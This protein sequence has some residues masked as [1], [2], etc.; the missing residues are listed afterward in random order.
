VK[1]RL[2]TVCLV[3]AGLLAGCAGAPRAQPT[4][5][6]SAS[7]PSGTDCLQSSRV[8]SF[9]RLD[10]RNLI[11]YA[12]DRQNAYHV[13][14]AMACS[15]VGFGPLSLVGEQSGRIC[16]H[17][18]AGVSSGFAARGGYGSNETCRIIG[19]TRLEAS[20]LQ[21]LLMQH[22]LQKSGEPAAGETEQVMP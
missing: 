7:S 12:P 14:L 17:S 5:A 3:L 19:V 21:E 15:D 16:S 9:E 6:A 11:L 13:E 18:N 8:R 4:A 10:Q 20:T 22:G 2:S 1:I